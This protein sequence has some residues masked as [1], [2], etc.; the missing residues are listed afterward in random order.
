MKRDDDDFLL[1]VR[2]GNGAWKEQAWPA[3]GQ[4]VD[5][6]GVCS[7]NHATVE[8]K[9]V[10]EDGKEF[11]AGPS[12]KLDAEGK[13]VKVAFE[14]APESGDDANAEAPDDLIGELTCSK[15]KLVVK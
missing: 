4:S 7:G 11:S 14:Q 1:A 12:L 13:K 15:T 9:V 5:F 3:K 10:H 6:D 8:I 2:V